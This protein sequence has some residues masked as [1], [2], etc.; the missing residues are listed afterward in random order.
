MERSAP[1]VILDD[2]KNGGLIFVVIENVGLSSAYNVSIKF[3]HEITGLNGEKKIT[4]MKIFRSLKFLPPGKKIHIFI[5]TFFSYIIRRQPL[6]VEATILYSDKGKHRFRDLI[7]HDLSIY[8]DL[9][10]IV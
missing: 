4:D 1:E 6:T 3:D 10:D 9:T 7:K 5:D 8:E 2:N